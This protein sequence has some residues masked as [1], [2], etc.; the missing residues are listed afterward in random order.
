MWDLLTLRKINDQWEARLRKKSEKT[1]HKENVESL[2][3]RTGLREH[4]S[5]VVPEVRRDRKQ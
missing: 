1:G 5:Q 3:E 2:N 4:Q